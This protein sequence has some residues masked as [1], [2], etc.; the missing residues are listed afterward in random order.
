MDNMLFKIE[1]RQITDKLTVMLHELNNQE[2]IDKIKEILN[3]INTILERE[4]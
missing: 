4:V 2:Q 3:S 1:I